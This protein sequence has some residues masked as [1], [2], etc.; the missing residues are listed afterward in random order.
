MEYK[1][2]ITRPEVYETQWLLSS[3]QGQFQQKQPDEQGR[4]V[5]LKKKL[6]K[7]LKGQPKG[8]LGKTL[9]QSSVRRPKAPHNTTQYIIK[10][11]SSSRTP[12][13]SS[14]ITFNSMIG[15]I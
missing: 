8:D 1:I 4:R 6:K 15:K 5:P 13:E 11:N 3:S 7:L 10:T 14:I 2:K 12:T 9:K